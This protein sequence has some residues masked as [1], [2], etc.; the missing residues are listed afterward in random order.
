VESAFVSKA[1]AHSLIYTLND[2][3]NY[4]CY[5][6]PSKEE[7]ENSINEGG[8][9][10]KGIH[11]IIEPSGGG[12]DDNDTF[13][14]RIAKHVRIPGSIIKANFN[15]NLSEDFR[16]SRMPNNTVPV[17]IFENWN[18]CSGRDSTEDCSNGNHFMIDKKSILEVLQKYNFCLI[19]KCEVNRFK[20]QTSSK[21]KEKYT[22][23]VSLYLLYPN[24]KIE[25]T[26][27]NP[28]IRE[29]NY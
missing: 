6:I 11:D 14:N 23:F 13:A 25:S 10:L 3:E 29:D 4:H 22:E 21:E 8:F 20:A 27:R 28:K 15:L 18:D 12:L 17:T 9:M 5:A 26:S 2:F 16:F 7:S 1:K 19:I 24:G